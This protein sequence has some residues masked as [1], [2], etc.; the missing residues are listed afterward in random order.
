MVLLDESQ[1]PGKTNSMSKWGP[2]VG[3]VVF[4]V[5]VL[6]IVI[7]LLLIKLGV[8]SQSSYLLLAKEELDTL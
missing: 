4:G 5:V 6:V 3:S 2:I 7:V 8:I 1:C